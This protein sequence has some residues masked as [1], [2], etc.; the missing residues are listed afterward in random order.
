MG[1]VPFTALRSRRENAT[2]NTQGHTL[3]NIEL[4]AHS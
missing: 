1:A 4:L 3:A 2:D